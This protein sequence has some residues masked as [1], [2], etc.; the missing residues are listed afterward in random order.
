MIPFEQKLRQILWDRGIS[1]LRFCDETGI[2]RRFFYRD[3]QR[4]NKTTYMAIAYYLNMKVEDM[5]EGT[6]AVKDWY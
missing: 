3:T 5:I 1:I 4:H 6:D 2:A